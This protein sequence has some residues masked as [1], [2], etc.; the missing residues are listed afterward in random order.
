MSSIHATLTG[1]YHFVTPWVVRCY[2][3]PLLMGVILSVLS[4]IYLI[5][6]FGVVNRSSL[7]LL[8]ALREHHNDVGLFGQLIQGISRLFSLDFVRAG[9][10]LMICCHALLMALLLLI[11]KQLY[12]AKPSRWALILLLLAHSS[13]NDFRAY[14][15]VEPLFWCCWLL[16]IYVLLLYY[17]Q[18]TILAIAVWFFT[19]LFATQFVV[20]AWFWLLLFPF[21]ALVWKPWRR[22]SVAYA[23]L[24]YTAIVTILLFLPVH[25]GETPL[26]WLMATWADNP[27]SLSAVL[28][29]NQS[30]WVKEE[31]SLMAGVFVFSGATSLVV[32]RTLISLGIACVGLAVYA[33]LRRQYAIVDS[34]R[35]RI[36]LYVAVFDLLIS[37]VLFVIDKDNDSLVSFSVSL[38]LF[39]LAALGLSYVFKKM[40]NANYSRLTV[41][42]I[43]WC[44]VAYIASGLIIFGPRKDY[45]R[46]AGEFA[47]QYQDLPLYSNDPFFLYYAA[48]NP[49]RTTAWEAIQVATDDYGFYYAYEKN[50]NRDLPQTLQAYTPID[51]FANQRGDSLL[52][53]RFL[54]KNQNSRRPHPSHQRKP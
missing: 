31:N 1:L 29:L 35:L 50:R 44:L 19:F 34:D 17:R 14:I 30:N 3:Q 25:R 41:L 7:P 42:V 32:I 23:L 43:V 8:W 45:L 6:D 33:L 9:H 54:P 51:R 5:A 52:I 20:A 28:G 47:Q 16:A 40:V 13:Y 49:N 26:Q 22:K 36:L 15:I 27:D 48:E 38:L 4:S 11:A 10:A 46:G 39:F 18:R 37:V 21:G 24:G 53:Y 12:F 2:R